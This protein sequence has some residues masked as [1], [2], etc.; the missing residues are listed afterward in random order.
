MHNS[1]KGLASREQKKAAALRFIQNFSDVLG[2][3]KS[4]LFLCLSATF[5]LVFGETKIV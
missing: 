4:F 2:V 3:L 1:R 5:F